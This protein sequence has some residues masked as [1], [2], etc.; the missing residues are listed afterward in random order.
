MLRVAMTTREADPKPERSKAAVASFV[1]G[2]SRCFLVRCWM[3]S[4]A[5]VSENAKQSWVRVVLRDSLVALGSYPLLHLDCT[6]TT[7]ASS[8]LR[9][10]NLY[11]SCKNQP[12]IPRSN[13]GTQKVKSLKPNIPSVFWGKSK[14]GK[15]L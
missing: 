12:T 9:R 4:G 5:V 6:S 7:T 1:V 2:L 3:R 10:L 15:P 8:L 13:K 14:K 11:E